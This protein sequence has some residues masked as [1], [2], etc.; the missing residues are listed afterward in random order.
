MCD[1]YKEEVR[2]YI[3]YILCVVEQY[4]SFH[5][6]VPKTE[7]IS[8]GKNTAYGISAKCT[9]DKETKWFFDHQSLQLSNKLSSYIK[10]CFLKHY[11]K[12]YN[13]YVARTCMKVI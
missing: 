8:T 11:S 4:G 7:V 1:L 6:V 3:N 13:S 9:R 5:R 12:Q 2:Y 10:E